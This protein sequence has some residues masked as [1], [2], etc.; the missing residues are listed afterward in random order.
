M[1]RTLQLLLFAA[2]ATAGAAGQIS[3]N[4]KSTDLVCQFPVQTGL[5]TNKQVLGSNGSSTPSAAQAASIFDSAVATQVSQ[6]PLAT[7]AAGEITVLDQQKI[8][9][10]VYD[11]GPIL[12]D[13]ARTIGKKKFFLGFTA[14]QY[15]FTNIDGISFGSLEFGFQSTAAN[16]PGNPISTTFTTER[17]RLFFRLNQ[18]IGIGTAGLGSKTD[19]SVIVPSERLS[20]GTGTYDSL[21]YIQSGSSSVATGPILNPDTSNAGTAS[22][23]GDLTFNVKRELWVGERAT[24]SGA[25]NFR[26]PT[27]DKLNFLGSGAW[28]FDPYLIFSYQG[29]LS[30][31]AKI[32]YQWNT[33]TDLNNPSGQPGAD[34]PLPGGV[35]FDVG[36][37]WAVATKFTLAGDLLGN[38]YLNSPTI[39]ISHTNVA[40]TGGTVQL[41]SS[42]TQNSSYTISNLSTGVKFK[43]LGNLVLSGNVL[44]QL[45]NTGLRSRPTPLLGISYSFP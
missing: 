31:H 28:G 25:M 21:S 33:S 20:L 27:G 34:R 38:Q 44:F 7:A 32:G 40:T 29:K 30:P 11:L 24:F 2:I 41:G 10:T 12:T 37:E 15:V 22:G 18:F 39:F 45:N 4:P 3:C 8:P 16:S 13:R 35:N 14:S 23:V 17:N 6:L 26:V 9:H 36:A 5:L 1:K 43:P 19:V 42:V